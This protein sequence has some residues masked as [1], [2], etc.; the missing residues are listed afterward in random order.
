[1]DMY[2]V[3]PNFMR[4]IYV[5]PQG[6][7]DGQFRGW[8]NTDGRDETL[9]RAIVARIE[10]QYC[11]DRTRYFSTGFSYGGSMSFTAALCMS[12]LFRGIGAMAGAPISGAGQCVP[13]RP[14]AAWINHGTDDEALSIELALPLRD[15]LVE[16]NGCTQQTAAVEPSPC[17]AYQG[18]DEGYP[19]V[20]CEVQGAGHEIPSYSSTAIAEFF[21]QF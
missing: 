13:E 17:V 21:Q 5:T 6:L 4:A 7:V 19:V 18:C 10:E 12:D 8:P 14:V 15:A 2:R 9:T 3:R 11:I 20:W 1:M 16:K